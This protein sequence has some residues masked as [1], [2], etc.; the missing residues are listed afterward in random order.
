MERRGCGRELRAMT[1][2]QQRDTQVAWA[3]KAPKNLGGDF[4]ISS[5]ESMLVGL[6]EELRGREGGIREV[7]VLYA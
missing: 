2:R 7:Y 3:K 1:G 5:T 6:V 4:L